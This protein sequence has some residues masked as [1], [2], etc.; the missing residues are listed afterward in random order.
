MHHRDAEYRDYVLAR[1]RDTVIQ[2]RATGGTYELVMG[3]RLKRY[4]WL[5]VPLSDDG[6]L[7]LRCASD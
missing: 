2:R 1:Y 3:R 6:L 4:Q 5:R 7:S